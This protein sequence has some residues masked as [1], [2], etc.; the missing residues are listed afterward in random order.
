MS[1]QLFHLVAV[2]GIFLASL[3]SADAFE[4]FLRIDGIRGDSMDKLHRDWIAVTAVGW[5]HQMMGG[6]TRMAAGGAVA[7]RPQFQPMTISKLLDSASPMLAQ[8]LAEGRPI[9]RMTLELVMQ[10]GLSP[11]AK[12]DLENALAVS[13]AVEGAAGPQTRPT[14]KISFNFG[15]IIWTVTS[16]DLNGQPRGEVRGAWDIMRGVGK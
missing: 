6:D 1:R 11:F 15:K 4:G 5:G 12:V 8:M 14:E 7:G 3:N 2:I 13:Y 10:P 16:F 9:P